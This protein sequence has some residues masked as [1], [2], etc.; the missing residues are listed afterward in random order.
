M[1]YRRQFNDCYVNQWVDSVAAAAGKDASVNSAAFDTQ[2]CFAPS[3]NIRV[4]A[5][6]A[7]KKLSFKLQD[8]NESNAN[9][10]DVVN[11]AGRAP[12]TDMLSTTEITAN[13]GSNY[14]YT[15][16]KRYVRVVVTSLDAAPEANVDILFQKHMLESKPRNAGF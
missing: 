6:A 16:Q 7:N 3:I 14:F 12:K 10:V 15:G 2:R 5:L 4:R 8:S 1:S 13:G 9:F 11:T